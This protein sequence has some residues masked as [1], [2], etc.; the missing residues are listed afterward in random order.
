MMRTCS[1]CK[2]VE[3]H[4]PDI[5]CCIHPRIGEMA[6]TNGPYLSY[7]YDEDGWIE[8]S[9]DFG[10]VNFEQHTVRGARHDEK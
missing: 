7:P 2:H 6:E 5:L 10:C 8:V 4:E 3:R 1:D 9:P